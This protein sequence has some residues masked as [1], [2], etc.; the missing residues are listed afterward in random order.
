[1]KKSVDLQLRQTRQQLVVLG[2]RADEEP[3]DFRVAA[4]HADSTIRLGDSHTPEWQC[5]MEAFELQ[6]G[7]R[8]IGLK[9]PIRFLSSSLNVARQLGEFAPKRWV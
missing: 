9:T 4:A 3:N 2:V 7:M 8:R 6:T 1:L 5:G